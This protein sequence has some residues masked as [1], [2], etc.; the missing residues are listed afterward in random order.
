MIS[1]AVIPDRPR[2][3]HDAPEVAAAAPLG[4]VYEF[5]PPHPGAP[6]LKTASYGS[7]PASEALVRLLRMLLPRTGRRPGPNRALSTSAPG[8]RRR[9]ARCDNRPRCEAAR[10]PRRF[11]ARL[12]T[13][14]PVEVTDICI[15]PRRSNLRHVDI[16]QITFG[17]VRYLMIQVISTSRQTPRSGTFHG[18][19]CC[20]SALQ[21]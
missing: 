19:V 6:T 9:T 8:H 15:V 1:S 11:P 20:S 10:V 21:L 4:S 3:G 18:H 16:N 7:K 13:L 2:P 12:Y 17:L 14:P 5:V